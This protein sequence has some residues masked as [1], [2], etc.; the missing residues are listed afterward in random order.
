VKIELDPHPE[1]EPRP[2]PIPPAAQRGPFPS[3][4]AEAS[5]ASGAAVWNPNAAAAWSLLFTPI[6][7][8]CLHYLN[9]KSL[10]EEE[11]AGLARIWFIFSI[12]LY[13]VITVL[14]IAM[15][16][17]DGGIPFWFYLFYTALWYGLSGRQQASYL[18]EKFGGE[19]E[20]R[21]LAHPLLAA[22]GIW[23]LLVVVL[24]AVTILRAF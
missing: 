8:S 6:F 11:R 21:P 12:V 14:Q 13:S 2:P 23:A 24:V 10:G 22:V 4:P 5:P 7:G 17:R 15:F 16:R 3:Q 9:W 20:H 1:P 19:Y 18:R